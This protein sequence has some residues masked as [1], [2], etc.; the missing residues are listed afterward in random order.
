MAEEAIIT[1]PPSPLLH[2]LQN[3]II[4]LCIISLQQPS[5]YA[6]THGETGHDGSD[7]IPV[8][9]G[10]SVQSVSVDSAMKTLIA[11]LQLIK[12]SSVFG[13]DIPSLVLTAR[14]ETNDRLRIRITDSEHHRWEVPQE[15]IPRQKITSQPEDIIQTAEPPQIPLLSDLRPRFH[16]PQ[17]HSIRLHRLPPPLRRCPLRHISRPARLR[18]VPRFQGPVH[19]AL[20]GSAGFQILD[21]RTRRAYEEDV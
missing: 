21:L 12:P 15:I 20:L 9:Y 5:S 14:L 10:Y 7:Q 8:G 6:A 3:L 1:K 13:P 2:F 16:T 4:F 11:H 17:H 18:Y 19:S